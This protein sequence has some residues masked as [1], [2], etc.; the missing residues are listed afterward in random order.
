MEAQRDAGCGDQS[1]Q[2]TH[3][4]KARV[5]RGENA[6]R[7]NHPRA[8]WTRS[9]EKE[10]RP[11]S[12]STLRDRCP[13]RRRRP[14]TAAQ[15]PSQTVPFRPTDPLSSSAPVSS[16]PSTLGSQTGGSP[17]ADPAAFWTQSPPVRIVSPNSRERSGRE[18]GALEGGRTLEEKPAGENVERAGD[19]AHAAAV[20]RPS[21]GETVDCPASDESPA[22]GADA[23]ESACGLRQARNRREGN[24]GTAEESGPR[25]GGCENSRPHTD[26]QDERGHHEGVEAATRASAERHT[27]GERP[28]SS[29]PTQRRGERVERGLEGRNHGSRVRERGVVFSTSSSPSSC[30][31]SLSGASPSAA[32]SPRECALP[33]SACPDSFPASLSVCDSAPCSSPVSVSASSDV[34]GPHPDAG[35]RPDADAKQPPDRDTEDRRPAELSGGPQGGV[36]PPG[37]RAPKQT[38][39]SN[40]EE[41]L[42]AQAPIRMD[43]DSS[44]EPNAVDCSALPFA[45]PCPSDPAPLPHAYPPSR[46][47][48]SPAAYSFIPHSLC[49]SSSG[50]LSVAAS[51]TASSP[52]ASRASSPCL[53][54]S[55]SPAPAAQP[56]PPPSSPARSPPSAPPLPAIPAWIRVY[57]DPFV[58]GPSLPHCLRC[59]RATAAAAPASEAK[60]N[61]GDT[62]LSSPCCCGLPRQP[63]ALCRPAPDAESP[64]AAPSS[65]AVP[66]SSSPAAVC[67]SRAFSASPCPSGAS[68][69]ACAASAPRPSPPHATPSARA[70]TLPFPLLATQL[71]ARSLLA[72]ISSDDLRLARWKQ[73]LSNLQFGV[74]AFLNAPEVIYCR[75]VTRGAQ[76]RLLGLAV[77]MLP[78]WMYLAVQPGSHLDAAGGTG[79]EKH[80]RRSAAADRGRESPNVLSSNPPRGHAEEGTTKTPLDRSSCRLPAD[81]ALRSAVNPRHGRKERQNASGNGD[82]NEGAPKGVGGRSRRRPEHCGGQEPPRQPGEDDRRHPTRPDAEPAPTARAGERPVDEVGAQEPRKRSRA[83]ESPSAKRRVLRKRRT[84]GEDVEESERSRAGVLGSSSPASNGASVGDWERNMKKEESEVPALSPRLSPDGAEAVLE[85]PSGKSETETCEGGT[86]SNRQGRETAVEHEAACEA[87]AGDKDSEGGALE[88]TRGTGGTHTRILRMLESRA[89]P[90]SDFASTQGTGDAAA[91]RPAF[92]EGAG[93]ETPGKLHTETKTAWCGGSENVSRVSHRLADIK[94]SWCACPSFSTSPR[95]SRCHSPPCACCKSAESF[96]SLAASPLST[97]CSAALSVSASSSSPSSAA[98]SYASSSSSPSSSSS[99]SSSSSASSPSSSSPSS[100]SASSPSALGCRGGKAEAGA[101]EDPEAPLVAAAGSL[102]SS[103]LSRAREGK[104]RG[105]ASAHSET[106]LREATHSELSSTE[107]A[108]QAPREAEPTAAPSR[109]CAQEPTDYRRRTRQGRATLRVPAELLAHSA[110]EGDGRSGESKAPGGAKRPARQGELKRP[111]EAEMGTDTGRVGDGALWVV[112][113]SDRPGA[114]HGCKREKVEEAQTQRDRP[115]DEKRGEERPEGRDG[116]INVEAEEMQDS[117]RSVGVKREARDRE[118]QGRSTRLSRG[119]GKC[120]TFSTQEREGGGLEGRRQQSRDATVRNPAT[121]DGKVR[122]LKNPHVR[123]TETHA[124]LSVEALA[125][126]NTSPGEE[127]PG[128]PC[129]DSS[130]ATPA[131]VATVSAASRARCST[132]GALPAFAS[133]EEAKSQVPAGVDGVD[134]GDTDWVRGRER[135]EAIAQPASQ[136]GALG[137]TGDVGGCGA[138][139]PH[140]KGGDERGEESRRGRDEEHKAN[141]GG[142]VVERGSIRMELQAERRVTR[143][144]LR[145]KRACEGGGGSTHAPE[146][147][148]ARPEGRVGRRGCPERTR[149]AEGANGPRSEPRMSCRRLLR[150]QPYAATQL[151]GATLASPFHSFSSLPSHAPPLCAAGAAPAASPAS[152][153]EERLEHLLLFYR[154]WLGDRRS[155]NPAREA[156]LQHAELLLPDAFLFGLFRLLAHLAALEPTVRPETENG[157]MALQAAETKWAREGSTPGLKRERDPYEEKRSQHVGDSGGNRRSRPRPRTENRTVKAAAK[158]DGHAAE[159]SRLASCLQASSHAGSPSTSWRLCGV[160][161]VASEVAVGTEALC[162]L[163]LEG[164][165]RKAVEQKRALGYHLRGTA[166][167]GASAA[168]PGGSLQMTPGNSG[169]AT[170]FPPLPLV[171]KAASKPPQALGDRPRGSAASAVP[172]LPSPFGTASLRSSRTSELDRSGPAG[173]GRS[174][175]DSLTG[176]SKR[177]CSQ[178]PSSLSSS[179]SSPASSSGR[180]QPRRSASHAHPAGS[181]PRE[182][183]NS[184]R[185]R[186]PSAVPDSALASRLRRPPQKP[187]SEAVSTAGWSSGPRGLSVC[188]ATLS[189]ACAPAAARGMSESASGSAG[190]RALLV[191]VE[192]ACSLFRCST[193]SAFLRSSQ[194]A[195]MPSEGAH[196][197]DS[198]TRTPRR[199]GAKANPR[200][201][202]SCPAYSSPWPSSTSCSPGVGASASACA[203]AACA[204]LS[205]SWAGKRARLYH[206][207]RELLVDFTCVVGRLAAVHMD[208]RRCCILRCRDLRAAARA[209]DSLPSLALDR[210]SWPS[211][212]HAPSDAGPRGDSEAASADSRRDEREGEKPGRRA[213]ERQERGQD[214]RRTPKIRGRN[215]ERFVPTCFRGSLSLELDKSLSALESVAGATEGPRSHVPREGCEAAAREGLQEERAWEGAEGESEGKAEGGQAVGLA[216]RR[217]SPRLLSCGRATISPAN[218]AEPPSSLHCVSAASA[219]GLQSAG[220]VAGSRLCR[221]KDRRK[222]ED[223]AESGDTLET[224]D[225]TG[226]KPAGGEEKLKPLGGEGRRRSSGEDRLRND[227]LRRGQ[228]VKGEISERGTHGQWQAESTAATETAGRRHHADSETK[229]ELHGRHPRTVARGAEAG[230]AALL[231]EESRETCEGDSSLR[232]NGDEDRKVTETSDSDSSF[233]PSSSPSDEDEDSEDEALRQWEAQANAFG[234]PSSGSAACAS[235]SSPALLVRIPCGGIAEAFDDSS[236]GFPSSA[237]LPPGEHRAGSLSLAEYLYLV[238]GCFCGCAD[239]DFAPEDITASEDEE[240]DEGQEDE[241]AEEADEESCEG[242]DMGGETVA[243]DEELEREGKVGRQEDAACGEREERDENRRC[244]RDPG[245]CPASEQRNESGRDAVGDR[246]SLA[247]CLEPEPSVEDGEEAKTAKNRRAGERRDSDEER[248]KGNGTKRDSA[249]LRQV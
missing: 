131:E 180:R 105:G 217:W 59:A 225:A 1:P 210:R 57:F 41:R 11:T 9:F 248:E 214:A 147:T 20:G 44:V 52:G 227:K 123:E 99:S 194:P 103:H 90:H 75:G 64:S 187:M 126:P 87:G 146:T 191:A 73:M 231:R 116:E 242:E 236:P 6:R 178:W 40:E 14:P 185:Q 107:R 29:W 157:G 190:K 106:G 68:A 24:D 161:K 230:G 55:G 117:G 74:R 115:N 7:S 197:V 233:H 51:V 200:S 140:K 189:A 168:G 4:E 26:D 172:G 10:Q 82:V 32:P 179:C 120:G 43:T 208:H 5:G 3:R 34:S 184:R 2:E 48:N 130:S 16:S 104:V 139:S 224:G 60:P 244:L 198:A 223:V 42:P 154:R 134:E 163:V 203:S 38:G 21:P 176:S 108:R 229:V 141:A 84:V 96:S 201:G 28:A 152:D 89:G 222:R 209:L 182:T 54:S 212:A 88:P 160:A 221:G 226:E 156:L 132:A 71:C 145:N 173:A 124:S 63:P 192:D 76:A 155:G 228:T 239:S 49:E 112:S 207:L 121:E 92:S 27:R 98:A 177:R 83:D 196:P 199:S 245:A 119:N 12:G 136:S 143:A 215:E 237:S 118:G 111:R 205:S 195:G 171:K 97:R 91:A 80:G 164:A 129:S 148:N 169:S 39:C 46:S 166:A 162:R 133:V 158:R 58:R 65:L 78:V 202:S 218:Q 102:S 47:S 137:A 77:N 246:R 188:P 22:A 241:Q 150:E 234:S 181:S 127:R 122:F 101:E 144:G 151:S 94:P 159:G 72:V 125:S 100:S 81:T 211:R 23:A 243:E 167:N 66:G 213:E 17:S 86:A 113:G 69:V 13:P 61:G 19:R 45:S 67:A 170:A 238:A 128:H 174:S 114:E 35:A 216:T 8:R 219:P 186:S 153:P 30:N 175:S 36:R 149:E 70:S 183:R 206:K 235:S 62:A 93:Q 79:E 247:P 95:A 193:V 109:P 18:G 165:E 220:G 138:A 110:S 142:T 31:T 135:G 232:F 37:G 249:S 240:E 204:M 50:P 56:I 53:A 15:E 25:K 33:P 85:T